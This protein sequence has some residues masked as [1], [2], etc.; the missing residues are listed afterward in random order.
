MQRLAETD[1]ARRAALLMAVL[2]GLC[3]LAD[4][5]KPCECLVVWGQP[6]GVHRE[7]AE[8]RSRTG[9]QGLGVS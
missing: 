4:A 1:M 7:A 8:T 6:K 5:Q 2:L 9:E 3:A